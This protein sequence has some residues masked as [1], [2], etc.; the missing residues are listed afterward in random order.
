MLRLR[1]KS[2]LNDLSK[3][4]DG[5]YYPVSQL[6]DVDDVIFGDVADTVKETKIERF[7]WV[8]VKR[9]FDETLEGLDN[10]SYIAGFMNSSVKQA[11]PPFLRLNI[12]TLL[13]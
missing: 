4:G 5:E 2:F 3:Y 7:S 9:R 13:V 10:L 8:D 1:R 6:E 12:K 11:Q